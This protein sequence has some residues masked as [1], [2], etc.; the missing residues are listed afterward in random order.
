MS[1]T[2]N[3]ILPRYLYVLPTAILANVNNLFVFTYLLRMI[4]VT[5]LVR[6]YST[7]LQMNQKTVQTHQRYQARI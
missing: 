5:Y 2:Q 4:T 1:N 7:E 6:L 3:I